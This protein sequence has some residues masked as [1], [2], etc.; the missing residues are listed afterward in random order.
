MKPFL[1]LILI[2]L[3]QIPGRVSIHRCS[4]IQECM[5]VAASSR[6]RAVVE[7]MYELTL[8]PSETND[9]VSM[10]LTLPQVGNVCDTTFSVTFQNVLLKFWKDLML[11][12][13]VFK[14]NQQMIMMKP[15]AMM[16]NLRV[17]SSL[18]TSTA[19]VKMKICITTKV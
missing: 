9:S 4:T 2:P 14:L 12:A 6:F 3:C 5:D 15:A 10:D 7:S 11:V 16:K 13:T 18:S 1:G 19:T 8:N 17:K